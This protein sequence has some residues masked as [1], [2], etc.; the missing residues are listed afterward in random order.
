MRPLLDVVEKA[1]EIRLRDHWEAIADRIPLSDAERAEQLPSG[2]LRYRNRINWACSHLYKAGVLEKPK[3][4]SIR[5]SAEGRAVV[6]LP[7]PDPITIDWLRTR[8][9][10]GFFKPAA[11]DEDGE[12]DASTGGATGG[13]PDAAGSSPEETI[14]QA[15]LS[16]HREVAG[17]LL[18]AVKAQPPDFFERL[19]VELMV[20]LGYGGTRSDAGTAIGK[21]GDG[22]IDGVIKEDRLGLDS[23]YLQAK[24][25]AEQS[26]GRPE[27]QAF[28]GALHGKNA[29]R[30]VFLTTSSFTKEA[31]EYVV[32]LQTKVVLIDGRQLAELMIEA[33]LGVTTFDTIQLKR[34]DVDYFEGE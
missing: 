25:Y 17:E 11:E 22:G 12:N 8:Y 30:G 5:L 26:V 21:S 27:V 9:G 23:I 19:V 13:D 7:P 28:V 18:E 32:A 14:E 10:E 15:R 4:G 6:A 1:G 2:G 20:A 29:R 24:R 31:K 33:G 34:V 3:R 16:L